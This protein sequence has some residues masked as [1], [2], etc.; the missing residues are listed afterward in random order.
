VQT[1]SGLTSAASSVPCVPQL[2]VA[3]RKSALA[4]ATVRAH[5]W[6]ECSQTVAATNTCNGRRADRSCVEPE[7][8]A[9][10]PCA[11]VAA[12]PDAI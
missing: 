4:I 5:P 3:S 2:R 1:W 7:R 11:T 12:G 6:D 10:V 9:S 8:G